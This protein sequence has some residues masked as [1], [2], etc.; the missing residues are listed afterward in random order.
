VFVTGV[1]N[2]I[3]KPKKESK[4]PINLNISLVCESCGEELEIEKTEMGSIKHGKYHDCMGE[5]V[6]TIGLYDEHGI[7]AVREGVEMVIE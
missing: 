1:S 7:W 2:V 3:G 4:M 5:H 6:R